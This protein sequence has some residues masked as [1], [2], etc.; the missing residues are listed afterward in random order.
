MVLKVF[1]DFQGDAGGPLVC[2]DRLIGLVSY[3]T[4]C[5]YIHL[6]TIFTDLRKYMDWIK[7]NEAGHGQAKLWVLLAPVLIKLLI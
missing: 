4:G 6:P 3:G 2:Q 7:E 5:G 1:V